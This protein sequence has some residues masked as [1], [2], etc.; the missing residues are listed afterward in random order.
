[1][2]TNSSPKFLSLTVMSL[3]IALYCHGR[4]SRF[5]DRS[6]LTYDEPVPCAQSLKWVA[7]GFDRLLA[8]YFWLRLVAYVGDIEL[9]RHEQLSKA[10]QFVELVTE[11]DP[12]F[13]SAYWFAAFT[14][15]GDARKPMR[16]ADILDFGIRNNPD[17]W[18]LPFIAGVNQYLY[19][20]N[21]TR[22]AK[23]YRLAAEYPGA[24]A[25]LQR[26]AQI[27]EAKS[28]Q[29]IKEANSWLNIFTSAENRAVRERAQER[30]IWLWG[31]VYKTAPNDAYRDRA[32]EV[33]KELGV[34]VAS[35][36]KPE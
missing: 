24:P 31:Q 4:L 3:A 35:L 8:D 19:A 15:G 16:A 2:E 30:A 13:V 11:L 6:E 32:R 1:M 33:L 12:Q 28:P 23:Y 26:Q 14:I 18:Y 9:Q 7:L 10:E 29:L 22:A 34:D 20:Q 25:W 17:N 27:L 5:V 36:K 21:E